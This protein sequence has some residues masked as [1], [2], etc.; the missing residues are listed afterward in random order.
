MSN[1]N[2]LILLQIAQLI[3]LSD[4][5]ISNAEETMILELPQRLGV[6]TT[7]ITSEQTNLSLASLGRSLQEHG[8]RCLAAK[9]ACL[10]AG[11]SRNPGDQNDINADERAGYRELVNTLNLS[12]EELAEIEWS[13]K[14]QLKQGK[15]LLQH[16][17]DALFGAGRWPDPALMGPEIPG[18]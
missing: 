18:L 13:A 5:S 1:N 11:A 6:D 4:G 3:A 7:S 17:G 9:I 16:L 14:E 2:H 12:E 10:V 8:D 15:T